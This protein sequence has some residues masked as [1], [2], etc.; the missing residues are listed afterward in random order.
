VADPTTAVAVTGMAAVTAFGRGTGALCD[1]VFAG[2][3]AFGPVTRFDVSGRRA[4]SAATLDAPVGLAEE[5]AGVAEEA[6]RSAGLDSPL[7]DSCPVLL[8]A[9]ADPALARS[10]D[11]ARAAAGAAGSAAQLASRCGLGPAI[12]AYTTGCVAAST[13][14]ID[15][16]LMIRSGRA[17]RVLVVAGYLVDADYFAAFDAGRA[18]SPAGSVRAFSRDRDGMLLGD[19]VA[20]VL[21][22]SAE[23]AER[24][25]APQFGL[26]A[27]WGRAGDAYHVCQPRPDGAGLAR[28]IGAALGRA[29]LPVDRIG[30]VN[31]HGTGTA[32]S[33]AAET[34]AL[35]RALGGHARQVPVSSTK[36]AHGHTLEASALLE[37]I[38]TVLALR[39]G[40]LPVNAS[41]RERDPDCALNLVLEPASADAE[42]ALSVN[43]AFGGA[44]T[45]LVVRASGHD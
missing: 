42:Y 3:T 5:L 38:I 23:A 13:A 44:N 21:L 12:R 7:W 4:R 15:A 20:A 6:C 31:A 22:E 41:F 2:R 19:A 34:A 24:R 10:P 18:L 1:A 16:A 45:A 35:H 37:L 27:G 33:D 32:Q 9:H 28:A 8:A 14:V 39:H 26:V 17:E 36:S 40:R 43:A 11:P 30:Y 29:G 25:G